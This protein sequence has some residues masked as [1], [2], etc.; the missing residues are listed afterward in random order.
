VIE[1][2]LEGGGE[3]EGQKGVFYCTYVWIS[4]PS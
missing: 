2:E 3:Q 1:E 4:N